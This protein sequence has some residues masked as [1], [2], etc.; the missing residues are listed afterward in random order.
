MYTENEERSGP[1]TL[2]ERATE[3][4]R[5]ALIRGELDER[6]PLTEKRVCAHLGMSRTPVRAALQTLAQEGLLGYRSQRGYHVRPVDA[7]T[8]AEAYE[9]R[10]VLEGLACQRA[11]ERGLSSEHR[12]ALHSCVRDGEAILDGGERRFDHEGWR[13]MN[14]RFHTALLEAAGSDTL[15]RVA[16]LA[17]RAPLA[18]PS[19]TAAWAP[20]PD[21]D[22]LA[23][24][25]RDHARILACVERGDA[26]RAAALM[27]E[28]I[29]VAGEIV[30]ASV[31]AGRDG[32]DRTRARAP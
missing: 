26:T 16:R 30:S 14:V 11:A 28:H 27:R 9:V 23:Q 3:A 6:A 10:G 29:T 12:A 13:R 21:L 22:L 17:E 19:V 8:V 5:E 24:A 18:A 7:D 15:L 25:Q 31:R 4:L 2:T 1:T 20:A 32:S